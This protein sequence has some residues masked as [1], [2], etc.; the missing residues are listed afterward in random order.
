MHWTL[1]NSSSSPNT[2]K[3]SPTW[4][5]CFPTHWVFSQHSLIHPHTGPHKFLP[6]RFLMY[7]NEFHWKIGPKLPFCSYLK[8]KTKNK[9]PSSLWLISLRRSSQVTR[10]GNMFI[11]PALPY[12]MATK[13]PV[14]AIGTN[15]SVFSSYFSCW[16]KGTEAMVSVIL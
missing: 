13:S 5:Q 11:L 1:L 14:F 3:A 10:V 9:K 4:A 12:W 2:L 8:E 7:P 16:N 6:L 15:T